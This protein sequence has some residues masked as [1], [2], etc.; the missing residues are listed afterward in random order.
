MNFVR[1]IFFHNS[2]ILWCLFCIWFFIEIDSINDVF[3]LG[4]ISSFVVCEV[5][6]AVQTIFSA[7]DVRWI[8]VVFPWWFRRRNFILLQTICIYFVQ[9]MS[10]NRIL[11][12][13]CNL[14]NYIIIENI[15]V[16][17]FNTWIDV[18][19]NAS[20]IFFKYFFCVVNSFS[21]NS[22]FS[23]FVNLCQ[24][25]DAYIIIGFTTAEYI[26]LILKKNVFHVNVVILDS[27]TF[28]VIIFVFIFLMCEF[29][30][31][32]MFICNFNVF[33]WT[34]GLMITF[35]MLIMHKLSWQPWNTTTIQPP[36]LMI[37]L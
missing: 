7:F 30:F 13:V 32:L 8:L 6:C 3:I 24:I 21:W 18:I 10:R 14:F 1:R 17:S 23:L 2:I 5:I 11:T 29:Q 28:C 4:A 22:F 19:L 31:S 35:F 36:L 15:C 16:F 12:F 26:C 34:F 27:V 37:K 9:F 20:I 33:I 25:V